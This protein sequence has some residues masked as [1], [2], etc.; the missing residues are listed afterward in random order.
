MEQPVKNR[1]SQRGIPQSLM[2]VVHRELT[3]DNG[4]ASPVPV[5]QEFEYVASAL[6]TEGR[7]SPVIENQS[8]RFG[9]RG[10]KLWIAAVPFGDREFLEQAR[11]P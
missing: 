11:Q 10:H 5:F 2:P 8:G 6:L 9:Q 7:Q 3:R 4:R 1:V